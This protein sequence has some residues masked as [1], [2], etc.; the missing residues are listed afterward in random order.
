MKLY[1]GSNQIVELPKLIEQNRT[2]DF[3]Q[4]FYT[5]S[6]ELQSVEFAKK[7]A[8]RRNGDAIVNEYDFLETNIANLEI[9]TFS[10]ANEEWLDFVCNNRAGIQQKF[11]YDIIIG[12]VANDD[13]YR[14]VGL[15]LSGILTKEQT[16]ESLKVKTL[17]NQYT[18]VTEKSFQLL[19]FI[20]SYTIYEKNY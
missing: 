1:H 8:I 18:F 16:L 6:N 19:H 12:P 2:L 13:V 15:Y 10:S 3:G 17:Y 5:T 11:T 20:K 7:V 14:T 4:G 9:K